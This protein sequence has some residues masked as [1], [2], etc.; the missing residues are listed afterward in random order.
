MSNKSVHTNIL[1]DLKEAHTKKNM[2]M[3]RDNP[4]SEHDLN[5]NGSR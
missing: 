2:K 3:R 1:K 5:K 4:L